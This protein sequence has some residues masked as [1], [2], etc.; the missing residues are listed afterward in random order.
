MNEREDL[1]W[2]YRYIVRHM[3]KCPDGCQGCQIDCESPPAYIA[4]YERAKANGTLNYD[5]L[6]ELEREWE[7]YDQRVLERVKVKHATE[8]P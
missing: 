3:W 1:I 5:E 2:I 6:L 8:R 7:T 4:D